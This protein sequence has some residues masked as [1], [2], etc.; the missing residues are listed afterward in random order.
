MAITKAFMEKQFKAARDFMV[1]SNVAV[2]HNS[3]N[4]TGT[5]LPYQQGEQVDES[6]AMFTVTGGVRLI[7]SELAAVWPKA[8]DLMEVRINGA[9]WT[10][11][12][13]VATRL[14]E[15]EVTMLVTYGERYDEEVM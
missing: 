1:S 10:T 8:G 11:Y 9:P 3:W 6:G 15:P 7:V 2:R 4:Y 12:V 14:D 5:R 13:I